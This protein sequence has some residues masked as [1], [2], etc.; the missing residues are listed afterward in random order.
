MK[1]IFYHV[2]PMENCQSMLQFGIKPAIGPRSQL[3]G[4]TEPLIYLFNSIIGM[5]DSLNVWLKNE[6]AE[7]TEFGI[8]E[9]RLSLNDHHL[10]YQEDNLESTYNSTIGPDKVIKIISPED[11]QRSLYED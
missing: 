4:A 2:T 10:K 9:I 3:V 5:A 8:I 7:K 1:R 6:F 11:F